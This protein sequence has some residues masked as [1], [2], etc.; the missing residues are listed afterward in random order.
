MVEKVTQL[1]PADDADHVIEN[2]K[3]QYKSVFIIG[4]DHD[5]T[6]Q[7]RASTDLSEAELLWMIQL[8]KHKLFN[9]DYMPE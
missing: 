8:F 7:V 3:G 1:R 2:A 5:D 4:Y 9:G 6:I